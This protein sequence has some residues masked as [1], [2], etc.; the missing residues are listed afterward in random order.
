[1]TTVAVLAIKKMKK[2]QEF[3]EVFAKKVIGKSVKKKAERTIY[4]CKITESELQLSKN[5][6]SKKRPKV[7]QIPFQHIVTT[8][9]T[10][11]SPK[12][13]VLYQLQ[14]KE[15]RY[16]FLQFKDEI[17]ARSVQD[18]HASFE[19]TQRVE[20]RRSRQGSKSRSRSSSTNSSH[21]IS[22]TERGYSADRDYVSRPER[23]MSQMSTGELSRSYI[24][25]TRK[26]FRRMSFSDGADRSHQPLARPTVRYENQAQPF[27]RE[28]SNYSPNP[29]EARRRRHH[30][31]GPLMRDGYDDHRPR[32][33]RHHQYQHH[34]PERRHH[35]AADTRPK[36][37]GWK[38]DTSYIKYVP[39]EGNVM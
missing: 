8:Y 25:Y 7:S 14:K 21:P 15:K 16:Y 38:S 27:A 2:K 9:F 22:V 32:E 11:D 12:R 29:Y 1:M 23:S 3:D 37:N 36:K 28:V 4:D 5:Q 10:N 33:S 35:R 26:S 13:I 6:E 24:D 34:K 18:K 17:D 31:Q 30:S 20:D 39:G 19:A